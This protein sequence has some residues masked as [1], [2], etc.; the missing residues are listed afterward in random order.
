MSKTRQRARPNSARS[1]IVDSSSPAWMLIHASGSKL[2]AWRIQSQ[3]IRPE[4][5]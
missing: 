3:R 5:S 4:R 2:S 1:A